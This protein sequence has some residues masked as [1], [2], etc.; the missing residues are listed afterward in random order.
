MGLAHTTVLGL[1]ADDVTTEDRDVKRRDFMGIAAK[2]TMGATLA[3][4]DL[5]V[6]AAPA[7]A[8]PVPDHIGATDVR[9]VEEMTM[10]LGEQDMAFGGGSCREA[11]VGYLNWAVELRKSTMTDDVRRELDRALS[12]LENLAGWTSYDMLL[13]SS[14]QRFYLRS[15]YSAKQAD[16]PARV[17]LALNRLGVVHWQA[18]HYGDAL[19]MFQLATRPAKEAGSMRLTACTW[20]HDAMVYARMGN[21]RETETA[22]S[23]AAEDFSHAESDPA[24]W[25]ALVM[26]EAELHDAAAL[27]YTDL[28]RQD[29]AYTHRAV[30]EATSAIQLRDPTRTR[31]VLLKRTTLALNAYRGGETDLANRTTSQVLA[32]LPEVS[33]RRVANRLRPLAI[34]AATHDSTAADLAHQLSVTVTAERNR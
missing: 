10:A 27:A 30:D 29:Q 5:A 24:A 19:H 23:R 9:Q 15:V 12:D 3:T 18:G 33:S 16:D 34:E 13:H 1:D 17:A 8:G 14:A 4:A 22:L 2:I 31:A 26:D 32:A 20:Q 11:I 28:A 25:I 7:T 6:L 21:V